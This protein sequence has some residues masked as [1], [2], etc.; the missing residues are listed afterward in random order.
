MGLNI[1]HPHRVRFQRFNV[2]MQMELLQG[3]PV[4][5]KCWLTAEMTS[6]TP[7]NHVPLCP[8][9][10]EHLAS[11]GPY[12]SDTLGL[13]CGPVIAFWPIERGEHAVHH[14]L[15]WPRKPLFLLLPVWMSK[16]GV[17]LGGLNDKRS[18]FSPLRD[19]NS[20]PFI[21]HLSG[22]MEEA[23]VSRS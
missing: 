9:D 4:D 2:L 23:A 8:W 14:I 10:G 17:T 12:F 11:W 5:C 22:I 20:N 13:R 7:N 15:T 6:G 1:V 21:C 16:V 18:W 3:C 19:F